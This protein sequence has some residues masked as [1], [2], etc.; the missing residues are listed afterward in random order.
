LKPAIAYFAYTHRYQ[1][2]THFKII[3]MKTLLIF[4]VQFMLIS[5]ALQSNLLAQSA[6]EVKFQPDEYIYI[7]ETKGSGTPIDLYS[8]VIQN[9]AIINHAK[10]SVMI[11]DVE[12]IATQ[13]DIELQRVRVPNNLLIESAQKFKAY[14]DR[15]IL[16]YYDFQFQTSRY[17]NGISFSQTPTLSKEEAI[18]I[19]H[20]TLLFQTLPDLI[21]VKVKAIDSHGE[22]TFGEASLRVINHKPESQYYFPLKG[23]WAAYGAPSLISHHRWGSIQEFAFDFV[24]IGSDGTTHTGDGSKLTDYYAYGA[25]V[26]AIGS[27]KVV[28]I[29][30]EETESNDNLKQPDETEEE[31]NQRSVKLQQVLLAK[32]FSHVMGNRIIIEHDNGEYSYY[33]HLK[34]GS[35]KVKQGDLVEKGEE[36]AALGHS[37]NSTEPHLHFHLTDGPDMVYSRSIPISFHNISLYPDYD[38]D[39]RHIHYGQIIL[40]ND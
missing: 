28:S 1:Q 4:F 17:L 19:T 24:K 22:Y 27:G 21:T 37:G 25:P 14:Q 16:K 11:K 30:D 9:I 32:G 5:I 3:K 15:G 29:S 6:I 26:Y 31:Y 18:V 2:I 33:L 8:T 23:A 38:T 10:D 34:K 39:I 13:G 12:I 7:Y 20:R 35:L 36:I 40:T